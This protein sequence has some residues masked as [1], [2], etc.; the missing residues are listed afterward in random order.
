MADF[1]N[2]IAK[3][4]ERNIKVIA[5][6]VDPID[7]AKKTLEKNNLTFPIGY[8]LDMNRISATIGA[9]YEEEKGYLHATGFIIKPGGHI[10]CAVYSTGAIGRFVAKDCLN[11][12][13]FYTK[14]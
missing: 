11:L 14:K 12:I 4:E 13:D 1:Q 9:F 8:G 3:F 7:K 5:A 10:S 6:S 2:H